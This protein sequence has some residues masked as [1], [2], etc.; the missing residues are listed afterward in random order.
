MIPTHGAATSVFLLANAIRDGKRENVNDWIA[1]ASARSSFLAGAVD[2]LPVAQFLI[3]SSLATTSESIR[4]S[5]R[6][7]AVA[8]CADRSTL[9]TIASM[10]LESEPPAWLPVAVTGGEV[11]HELIPSA[12][13]AALSWLEPQLDRLLLLAAARP[14][15]VREEL[16]Q[17]IGRAAELV[18]LAALDYEG[19]SPVHVSLVSD[20]FGYDVESLKAPV[21]QWEVKGGTGNTSTS[22]HLTRHEF[23]I[24][25]ERSGTWSLVQVVF[26]PSVIV[27][28]VIDSSHVLC[29]RLLR[30]NR[31]AELV[32][33]DSSYFSWE[34][35]AVVTPPPS[36]WESSGLS[37]PH[38]F[39]APNL[40][41]LGRDVLLVRSCS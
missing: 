9:L 20:R 39:S 5:P 40:R 16:A 13:R 29:I 30:F 6:L 18:V 33:R 21:G 22:F 34:S 23:D 32:P 1:S 8:E 25:G 41:S 37:V 10:I 36:A 28:D 3:R 2:H 15:P 31:L 14:S 7:L 11:R 12:D 4:P 26:Q 17:G 24:G 27:A 35:S 19:A 38:G